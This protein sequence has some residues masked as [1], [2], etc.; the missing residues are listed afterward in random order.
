LASGSTIKYISPPL[1][2]SPPSGPP[3]A[4]Y[5]SLLNVTAPLPPVS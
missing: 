2:P 5:F 1:P 3:A 4:T